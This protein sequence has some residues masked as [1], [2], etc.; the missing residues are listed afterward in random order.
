MADPNLKKR[1]G[2]GHADPE[3]RRRPGL[4]FF[5]W[6]FGPFGVEIKEGLAGGGGRGGWG[7]FR[8]CKIIQ[9]CL[10]NSY[11]QVCEVEGCLVVRKSGVRDPCSPIQQENINVSSGNLLFVR[12]LLYAQ[13]LDGTRLQNVL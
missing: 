9:D 1:R 8:H 6:L 12:F 11:F 4:I 13:E 7:W 10:K 2:P 3:I 5:F